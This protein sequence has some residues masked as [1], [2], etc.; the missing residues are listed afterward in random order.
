MTTLNDYIDQQQSKLTSML[1]EA[2]NSS[3]ED[4]IDQN[5]DFIE[6]GQLIRAGK[7]LASWGLGDTN[8]DDL[9][10]D[11]NI[12]GFETAEMTGPDDDEGLSELDELRMALDLV[13]YNLEG[14][15]V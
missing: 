10:R 6:L 4:I 3:A 15:A 12:L 1:E 2:I 13:E 14:A 9:V 7:L 5:A 11:T 8:M